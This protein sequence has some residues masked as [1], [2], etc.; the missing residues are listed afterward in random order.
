MDRRPAGPPPRD[1]DAASLDIA[2]LPDGSRHCFQSPVMDLPDGIRLAV[3]LLLL[4]GRSPG[5]RLVLAGG[6]HGD[7]A[8]GIA[9][10]FALWERL[11]P[12]D[13]AGR[14]LILPIANPMAFA[15][16]QRRSPIDD[17]DLNRVCPGDADGRP[18]ERLAAALSTLVRGNADFLYTLHGWY[19]TG[20]AFP[21]VEFDLNGGALREA[22]RRACFAA[23]FE[24]V[25]AADWPAGLLP[26]VAIAAGIP[27]MESEIGGLGGSTAANVEFLIE[28][29]RMLMRHLGMTKGGKDQAAEERPA[30]AG[31][32][33]HRHRYVEAPLGGLFDCRV[34]L[35]ARVAAG[36]RLAEI[37]D[38][39]GRSIA[40]IDAPAAGVVVT[41]RYFLSTAAGDNL[42]TIL[43]PEAAGG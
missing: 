9:A 21:H 2:S 31:S 42:F 24:L 20:R 34:E 7:E 38:A 37:R 11:D 3:P 17:L 30:E 40:A 18:T 39:T 6:V 4:C 29:I 36:E 14:I 1:I 43:V 23:G 5:P 32:A 15:A 41:R 12:A 19:A 25:V 35:G 28:R 16:G 22:S 27:A 8:D 10:C 13:F 26:K 33:V